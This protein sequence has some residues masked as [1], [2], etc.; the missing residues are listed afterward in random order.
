MIP[1]VMWSPA[2]NPVTQGITQVPPPQKVR[3]E[4]LRSSI[5]RSSASPQL[6][7]KR[8]QGAGSPRICL[9]SGTCQNAAGRRDLF[10]CPQEF[11]S[12]PP[13]PP[14]RLAT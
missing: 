3:G 6:Y 11:N 7:P 13:P 8:A 14:H 2:L 10:I 5:P 9:G 4:G 1:G 12:S